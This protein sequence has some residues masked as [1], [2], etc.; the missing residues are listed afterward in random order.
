[1]DGADAPVSDV[2]SQGDHSEP[3]QGKHASEG[4]PPRLVIEAGE[5]ETR[6]RKH[7]GGTTAKL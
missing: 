7:R 1:M 3:P 4:L 6:L 5:I 2:L